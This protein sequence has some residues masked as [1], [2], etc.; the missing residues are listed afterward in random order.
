MRRSGKQHDDSFAAF[1]LA[2]HPL[3]GSAAVG[4]G[5]NS[6]AGDDIG[7]LE[8]IWRHLPAAGR[9]ALFETGDNRWVAM[10]FESKRVG[11]CF[12]REV[13]FGRAKSAH[14]D[15]DLGTRY[16]KTGR[17]RQAFTVIADDGLENDLNA[18]LVELLGQIQRVRIL[19]E[20]GQQ[21]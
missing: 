3:S 19:T 7:L 13:V 2:A 12:A 20:R 9:E 14:E 5:Q 6:C 11:Y 16:G 1:I 10:K 4:V 21:L 8:I 18:K 15:D 17:S